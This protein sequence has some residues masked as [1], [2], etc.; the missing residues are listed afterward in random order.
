M[1]MQKKMEE[2]LIQTYRLKTLIRYNNTPRIVNESIAE[3]MYYVT[4]IV[5][6][7]YEHY[8]F[9]LPV[10]MKMALFHDIPEIFLSD[11]PNDTKT[12]F[13]EMGELSRKNA[14]KASNMIDP[15]MTPFIVEYENQKNTE[16]KIVK[17]AD[18]LSVLQYTQQEAKL[19]NKYME[20]IHKLTK[21]MLT[22][23]YS[24]LEKH[25]SK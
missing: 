24:D 20:K 5:Y 18:V 6:K 8:K 3:H 13:P 11:I 7:L 25:R 21:D 9:D 14:E 15:T 22:G 23:L 2:F 1:S 12:M 4:L 10:A 19:G 17:L 16:S